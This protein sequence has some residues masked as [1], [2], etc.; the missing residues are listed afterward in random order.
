MTKDEFKKLCWQIFKEYGF[1]KERR[2]F[3]NTGKAN[4]VCF[5]DLQKSNYGEAYYINCRFGVKG[6]LSGTDL[7]NNP[8]DFFNRV[9]VMSVNAHHGAGKS[10]ET[11]MIYY[12]DY[13]AEQIIFCLKSA[14]DDWVMPPLQ[15]GGIFVVDH[16]NKYMFLKRNT[17]PVIKALLDNSQ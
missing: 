6:I 13:T 11:D 12:E 16:Q 5:I 3:T 1:K 10:T 9:R 8:G 15:V 14:L 17:A 7:A 2:F 4:V